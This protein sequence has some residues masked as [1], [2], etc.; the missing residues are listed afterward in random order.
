MLLKASILRCYFTEIFCSNFSVFF[1]SL[2]APF[3]SVSFNIPFSSFYSIGGLQLA[4]I[5]VVIAKHV[6]NS[7]RI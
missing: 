6:H 4:A 5:L 3:Y 7:T 2:V 1:H